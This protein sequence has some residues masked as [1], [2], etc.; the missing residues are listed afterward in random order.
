MFRA[1]PPREKPQ[2]D[3]TRSLSN[4][5]PE[6]TAELQTS[7]KV[8]FSSAS[9]GRDSQRML[10]CTLKLRAHSALQPA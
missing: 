8:L 10:F 9:K 2:P 5:L 4:L 3:A 1:V 6:P 7:S